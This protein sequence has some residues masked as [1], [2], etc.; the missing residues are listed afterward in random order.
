MWGQGGL[1]DTEKVTLGPIPRQLSESGPPS[2]GSSQFFSRFCTLAVPSRPNI[3]WTLLS[4]QLTWHLILPFSQLE[5]CPH[6][7]S[8]FFPPTDLQ[9]NLFLRV[10][11]EHTA[12]TTVKGLPQLQLP[13]GQVLRQ[14]SPQSFWLRNGSSLLRLLQYTRVNADVFYW[15]RDS[16]A[17]QSTGAQFT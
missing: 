2:T 12:T 7:G 8:F 6:Q 5:L 11:I 13:R 1:K 4:S 10:F 14:F 3:G 15:L 16:A 17:Q 9:R